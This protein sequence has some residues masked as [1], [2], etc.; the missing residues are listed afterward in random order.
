MNQVCLVTMHSIKHQNSCVLVSKQSSILVL[1]WIEI[2][3]FSD[4]HLL[5]ISSRVVSDLLITKLLPVRLFRNNFP[6]STNG[7]VTLI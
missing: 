3:P 2:P 6:T 1:S 7:S 5:K 4:E